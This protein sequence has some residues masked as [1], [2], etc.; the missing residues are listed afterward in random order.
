MSA[1]CTLSR[2]QAA[3]YQQAVRDLAEKLKEADGM[4]RPRARLGPAHEALKQ[5]CNHGPTD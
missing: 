1:F 3:L 5:I 2:E 4:K